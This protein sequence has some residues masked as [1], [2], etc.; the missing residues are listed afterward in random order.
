MGEQLRK[1]IKSQPPD[2]K[3]LGY[4]MEAYQVSIHFLCLALVSQIWENL[5]L[6]QSQGTHLGIG[7]HQKTRIIHFLNQSKE[8]YKNYSYLPLIKDLLDVLKHHQNNNLSEEIGQLVSNLELDDGLKAAIVFFDKLCMNHKKGKVP[9]DGIEAYCVSAEEYLAIFF[10]NLAFVIQYKLK[11]IKQIEVHKSRFDKASFRHI[12]YVLDNIDAGYLQDEIDYAEFT[13]SKSV[14]FFKIPGQI[15][16]RLNLTPLVID[17]NALDEKQDAE[18]PNLY[19]YAYYD[20]NLN[21]YYF[22]K[23]NNSKLTFV[24]E[25]P[26]AKQHKPSS[27]LKIDANSLPQ[28]NSL[29]NQLM[30]DFS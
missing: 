19:Y 27:F 9:N 5:F 16:P 18:L 17:K 24:H 11:T 6:S 22:E 26:S 29:L 14:I 7:R 23:I 28:L 2:H 12:H 10:K 30:V 4:M 25:K 20:A 13:D 3:R 8:S 15:A 1:V 21:A